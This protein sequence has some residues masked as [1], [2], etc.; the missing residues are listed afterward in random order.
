MEAS[1]ETIPRPRWF[2]LLVSPARRYSKGRAVSGSRTRRRNRNRRCCCHP[3]T[4]SRPELLPC[5]WPLSSRPSPVKRCGKHRFVSTHIM[6][7]KS[8][9]MKP[10]TDHCSG[11]RG[12]VSTD[13]QGQKQGIFGIETNRSKEATHTSLQ[14]C[15]GTH[16]GLSVVML[17]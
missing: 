5:R 1:V 11:T 14:W 9:N 7:F 8:R 10:I 12:L 3:G 6:S 16:G 17:I 15:F 13:D 2:S 4:C